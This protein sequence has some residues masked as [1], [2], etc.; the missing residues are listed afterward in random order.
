MIKRE[1]LKT[2]RFFVRDIKSAHTGLTL[3]QVV[4]LI[5]LNLL[6][7]RNLELASGSISQF[8]DCIYSY[9]TINYKIGGLSFL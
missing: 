2:S 1:L 8:L 7:Q 6:F 9:K 5:V 4:L 3:E